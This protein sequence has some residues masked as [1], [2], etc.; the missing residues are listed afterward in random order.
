MK[1]KKEEKLDKITALIIIAVVI[2]AFAIIP[3]TDNEK[4]TRIL[5]DNGYTDISLTGWRPLMASKGEITAT[6][7]KATSPTGHRVSGAV[8]A[9]FYKGSTIRFE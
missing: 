8:T 3:K 7:F 2:G 5:R 6:G 9:G 4:A 1:L